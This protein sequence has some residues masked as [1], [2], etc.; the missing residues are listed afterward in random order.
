MSLE[1]REIVSLEIPADPATVWAHL[2]DPALVRRWH[3]WE[4]AG[5]EDE[6]RALVTSAVETRDLEGD[7]AVRTLTWPNHD[8]VTVAGS[9]HEPHTTRLTVTRPSHDRYSDDYDGV[10]DEHDE[11][12]LA[13]AHQLRFALR[14]HPGQER[15]TLSADG[16]D[17][18]DR[19]DRLL[20]RA[21]LHGVRGVPVGGHLQARRPDGT[22]LGG[23]VLYK[24][25]HQLGLQLHGITESL[26]VIRER[27]AGSH[28]PHGTVDAVL[29]VYGIDDETFE[30]V[31]Q[32]WSGW[33]QAAGAPPAVVGGR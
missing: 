19:H 20:D 23:T 12:W 21:G 25:E 10:L 30:Q 6:I 13:D 28:P 8:A 24:T 31:M 7:R 5:L 9:A 2:R 11:R 29:S 3:G 26:L 17:A 1:R 18:G 22:L 32:R 4:H 15:R 14:V 27:P 16:L 33:W